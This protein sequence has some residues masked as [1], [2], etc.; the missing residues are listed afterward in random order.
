MWISGLLVTTACLTLSRWKN[1]TNNLEAIE[2]VIEG[3]RI[4][5]DTDHRLHVGGS[6]S[7]IMKK[8]QYKCVKF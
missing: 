1:L 4:E 8:K 5:L 2:K 3:I 6:I 7:V